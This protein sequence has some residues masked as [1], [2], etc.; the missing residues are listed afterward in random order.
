MVE[1]LDL[2][3]QED[4]L[5]REDIKAL[6]IEMLKMKMPVDKIMEYIKMYSSKK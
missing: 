6:I 3:E 4:V 5:S 1:D 2:E